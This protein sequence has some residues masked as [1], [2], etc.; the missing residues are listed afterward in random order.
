MDFNK[1]NIIRNFFYSL[2]KIYKVDKIY[3]IET[4]VYTVIS[5]LI[6]FMYPYILKIAI[7][8]IEQNLEFKE[9]IIKVLVIVIIVL[10]LVF[11]NQVC[12][13]D[14]FYRARKLSAIFT[15][16]YH[17]ESLKTDYE[18]FELPESQ[19]A[20]E[21]GS[22]A[23]GV[24]SGFIG[25]YTN[26][27]T[28]ISK[29]ITFIIGCGIILRV[30]FWL[31]GIIVLL[32]I[33]KLFL[34]SYNT[35]KEKSNFH[36]K[37]P[38]LWR[39][40]NYTDNISKNL[41]IG[42]DL[43]IYEMDK[44]IDMERQKTIDE[45]MRLYKKE[46][47]RSNFINI[48]IESLNI[49]DEIALYAFMIYEVIN[50]NMSIADFTFI[51]SAIRTLSSSLTAIISIYSNNLSQSLQVNDYRKFMMMDLSFDGNT[52]PFDWNEVE[53]E[54]KN[55]SYSYYMQE[56]YT[57]KN[58]SFKIHK[59]ERIALV[60]HNGAGKTTL[61][62]LICGFYHPTE[63]EI[64]INGVNIDEIDRESLI[65][66]IAPVFQDSN[67]YAV[68][69]KENVAMEAVGCIDEEKLY[70]ALNLVGLTKKIKELKNGV[71]TIITRDMDDTGVELSGGESQKLSIARAIY[72]D[73]PF[74][75]L[76]EPTSALD[77]L[78]E[79]D[80]YINLNKIINNHS[81]I[82]ISHRLSS[83]KFCDRIF[84][85]EKGE[86]LEVGTHEELMS[87]DSEYKKLFNM[88]AEYYKEAEE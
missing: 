40:I 7:E 88:Q 78:A 8:A 2:K 47:I 32:A 59:G 37:T 19:D 62:K 50:H 77:P 5:A 87:I 85:L 71:N 6:V 13:R 17:L 79:Y 56:G 80:L 22:R 31:I 30:S 75:I 29:I 69:I 35:K 70:N 10:I 12:W 51:I 25:L 66:L 1:P 72:K 45:Y 46:E 28:T 48:V 11:I 82:F 83:T 65:K 33:L 76:D 44:F 81:A 43:R 61:I 39:K 58:L 42:K 36:D 60:G 49:L 34:M 86:L 26:M 3:V 14:K 15:R 4:I 73:A 55:V 27:F 18:K 64:L 68:S 21:K 9:L 84:Y 23:L 16:E 57:L 74:V 67:H 54:F 63:G 38:G 52:K 53:I 24:R 41:S 20:F